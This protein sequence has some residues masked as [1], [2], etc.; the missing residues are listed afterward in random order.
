MSAFSHP[1]IVQMGAIMGVPGTQSDNFGI[2]LDQLNE[3]L[4][5]KIGQ[6]TKRERRD[7]MR[8]AQWDMLFLE[9]LWAI[10]NI[11]RATRYLQ[12]QK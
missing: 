12:S 8:S 6:W 9:Q 4:R 10:Y 2:I 5:E 7:E 11:A 3:T 1:N